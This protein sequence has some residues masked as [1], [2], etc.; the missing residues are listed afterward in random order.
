M[1]ISSPHVRHLK[2]A[3]ASPTWLPSPLEEARSHW[4]VYRLALATLSLRDHQRRAVVSAARKAVV[5]QALRIIV[6]ARFRGVGGSAT[7]LLAGAALIYLTTRANRGSSD[8]PSAS[9]GMFQTTLLGAVAAIIAL[10]LLS[11]RIILAWGWVH[12]RRPWLQQVM[13]AAGT[14]VLIIIATLCGWYAT[15]HPLGLLA[16][17]AWGIL[18]CL[19]TTVALIGCHLVIG[20]HWRD[21]Y[22]D[23]PWSSVATVVVLTVALLLARDRRAWSRPA[24]R[25]DLAD[26]IHRHSVHTIQTYRRLARATSRSTGDRTEILSRGDRLQEALRQYRHAL[27]DITSQRDYDVLL[28][29]VKRQT[30]ALANKEWDGLPAAQTSRTAHLAAGALYGATLGVLSGLA[31]NAASEHLPGPLNDAK[32]AWISLVIFVILMGISAWRTSRS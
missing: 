24:G 27:L 32:P 12:R 18:V 22:G 1:G 20:R 3:A 13:R 5:F 17:L 25:K 7:A 26:Q 14:T 9:I 30:V 16:G 10:N 21:R 2:R 11:R 23:P 29:R 4:A 28:E 31:V 19:A 6:E 15:E 8:Q